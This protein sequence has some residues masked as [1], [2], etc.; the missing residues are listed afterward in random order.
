MILL[1]Y[2]FYCIGL[3]FLSN[4]VFE[5]RTLRTHFQ[6]SIGPSPPSSSVVPNLNMF[7]KIKTTTTPPPPPP[8]YPTQFFSSNPYNHNPHSHSILRLLKSPRKTTSF[9]CNH[10][11]IS[12][13]ESSYKWEELKFIRG[14]KQL[15]ELSSWGIGGACNYFIQVFDQTQLLSALRFFLSFSFLPFYSPPQFLC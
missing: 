13:G 2:E 8:N 7:G 10:S 3:D 4:S 6:L 12:N 1:F 14:E 9:L 5:P 15:K 11:G